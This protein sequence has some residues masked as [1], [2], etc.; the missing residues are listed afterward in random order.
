M[1]AGVVPKLLKSNDVACCWGAAAMGLEK[2]AGG[3]SSSTAS[4]NTSFLA[5]ATVSQPV[6]SLEGTCFGFGLMRLVPAL[7]V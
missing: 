4:L 3:S 2:V 7:P 6:G 1:A 5:A